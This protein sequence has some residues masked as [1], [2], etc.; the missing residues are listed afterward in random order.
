MFDEHVFLNYCVC[1]NRVLDLLLLLLYLHIIFVLYFLSLDYWVFF[2]E[3]RI[4]Y[5]PVHVCLLNFSWELGFHVDICTLGCPAGVKTVMRPEEHPWNYSIFQRVHSSLFFV[6]ITQE[7]LGSERILTSLQDIVLETE[8][9]GEHSKYTML[10]VW[11]VRQPRPVT[12]KLPA[13]Y[14]LLTGQRV[15]DSLFP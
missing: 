4:T 13:N 1:T 14:P 10:Q 15:L 12:E 5:G 8:F 11:P 6:Y 3:Q 2:I 7:A 9:D